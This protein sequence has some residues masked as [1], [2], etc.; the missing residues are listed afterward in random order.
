MALEESTEGLEKVE[1]NSINLYL[2]KNLKEFLEQS[3]T[4]TI[5]YRSYPSGGG[6]YMITVGSGCGDSGGCGGSC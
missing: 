2:D 3:G 5:D 1:S 4:V 6:G